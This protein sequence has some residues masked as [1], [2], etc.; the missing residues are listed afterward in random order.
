MIATREES[1]SQQNYSDESTNDVE[2]EMRANPQV[3]AGRDG[4]PEPNDPK[5]I[6]F[7]R[8]PQV[9]DDDRPIEDKH[10]RKDQRERIP[11]SCATW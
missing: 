2:G 1:W 3:S 5:G 11:I 10:L 4:Q 9:K 7:L 6:T 8:L